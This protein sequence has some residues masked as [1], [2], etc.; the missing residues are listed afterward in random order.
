MAAIFSGV[1][2]PLAS[3]SSSWAMRVT[4]AARKERVELPTVSAYSDVADTIRL[5]SSLGYQPPVPETI[6]VPLLK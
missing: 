2:L 6:M 5:H 1:A 3:C 4:A